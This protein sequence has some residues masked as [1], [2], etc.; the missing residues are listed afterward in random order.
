MRATLAIVGCGV[1]LEVAL[2]DGRATA[3]GLVALPGPTP[4]SELLVAAVDLLLRGAGLTPA[5]LGLVLAT[6]GP[7]SFTGIRVALATAQGL[8]RAVGCA[9]RAVPSLAV[10]AARAPG[11]RRLAVQRARRGLVYTQLF[12]DRDGWPHAVGDVRIETEQ[13]LTECEEPVVAPEGFSP[14]VGVSLLPAVR[15]AAEALLSLAGWPAAQGE[16]LAPLYVEPP[17]ATAPAGRSF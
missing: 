17:Q 1:R 13:A 14:P 12:E 16:A 7:G 2:A 15:S 9:A 4:R 6:R 3:A 5:D 8:A 10:V 11:G